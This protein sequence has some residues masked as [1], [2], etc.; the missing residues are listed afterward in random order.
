MHVLWDELAVSCVLFDIKASVRDVVPA[1]FRLVSEKNICS[2]VP[3]QPSPHSL[4]QQPSTLLVWAFMQPVVQGAFEIIGMGV[5]VARELTL[6]TGNN[7]IEGKG[8]G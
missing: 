5:N 2:I 1:G 3:L 8:V 6:Q 7:V 4:R